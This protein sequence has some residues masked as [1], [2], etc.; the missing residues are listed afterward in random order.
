M[1]GHAAVH[2]GMAGKTDVCHWFLATAIDL[3]TN[4]FGGVIPKEGRYRRLP[5]PEGAFV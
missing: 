4:A 5:V 1:S 2:A 3:R